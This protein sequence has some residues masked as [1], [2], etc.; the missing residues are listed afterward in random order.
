MKTFAVGFSV[1]AVLG[2]LILIIVTRIKNQSADLNLFLKIGLP[3]IIL[4]WI[5]SK[6]IFSSGFFHPDDKDVSG[7]IIEVTELFHT[8]FKVDDGSS[9]SM[10][11]L[12]RGL[13]VEDSVHHWRNGDWEYFK[14]DSA[15]NYH[16]I[17]WINK[18]YHDNVYEWHFK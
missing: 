15:D 5:L 9:H 18:D 4:G 10:G 16:E 12:Y 1:L 7:K 17:I 6:F 3:L 13:A 11:P 14:K 8:S 2:V